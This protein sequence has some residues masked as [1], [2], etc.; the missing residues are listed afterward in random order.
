VAAGASTELRSIRFLDSDGRPTTEFDDRVTLNPFLLLGY[1]LKAN[2]RDLIPNDGVTIV[3]R[4]EIDVRTEDVVAPSRSWRSDATV[5]VPTFSEISTRVAAIFSVLWQNGGADLDVDTFLPR[6]YDEGDE[7]LQAGTFLK[8]GLE[9]IQPVA[10]VDRGIVLIPISIQSVYLYGF[11][12]TLGQSV[13]WTD[14][15]SS[16]GAGLGVRMLFG[17]HLGFDARIGVARLL[18]EKEWAVTTR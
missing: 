17:H 8:A 7:F 12:E 16:I 14:R 9:V 15:R 1:R 2:P 10:W 13:D 3:S 11:T 5:Y 18:E 4:A 6:G